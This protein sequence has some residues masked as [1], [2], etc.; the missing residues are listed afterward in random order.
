MSAE[1]AG[2]ALCA[3]TPESGREGGETALDHGSGTGGD[4]CAGAGAG[5]AVVPVSERDCGAAPCVRRPEAGEGFQRNLRAAAG[6]FG[7][8][9]AR[10]VACP[11][12]TYAVAAAR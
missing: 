6:G 7:C 10:G 8:V 2:S 9:G 4:G 11:L 1:T 3:P 5:A 12:G